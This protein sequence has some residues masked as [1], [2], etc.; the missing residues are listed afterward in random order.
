MSSQGE[1][2]NFSRFV[3]EEED[4]SMFLKLRTKEKE[5][6]VDKKKQ[7]AVDKEREDNEKVCPR[8]GHKEGEG[9]KCGEK[10]FYSTVNAYRIPKGEQVYVKEM[11]NLVTFE[12]YMM[13]S[14]NDD[15]GFSH[16]YSFPISWWKKWEQKNHNKYQFNHVK[17]DLYWD[18][19]TKDDIH[20]FTY[21]YE[22]GKVYSDE[23]E[24][25]F[26]I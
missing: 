20:L 23:P 19:Y 1:F 3:A 10:D 14:A 11:K 21:N 15:P 24:Y 5:E 7:K 25:F 26:E 12:N 4:M 6:P 2:H 22:E 18:V 17:Q 9:C 16:V 13:E 8:C